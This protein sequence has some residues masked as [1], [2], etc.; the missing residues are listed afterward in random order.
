MM[1]MLRSIGGE[2]SLV[3]NLQEPHKTS[4]KTVFNPF[5]RVWYRSKVSKSITGPSEQLM[6]D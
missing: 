3:Q 2:I 6:T 5:I 4:N 1:L